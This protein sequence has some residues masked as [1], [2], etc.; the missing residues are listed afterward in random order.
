[1]VGWV[2]V[3]DLRALGRARG[4]GPSV[5]GAR[6]GRLLLCRS[7]RKTSFSSSQKLRAP[8]PLCR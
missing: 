8:L 2:V 7:R 4:H 3:G 6:N 1:M 5:A